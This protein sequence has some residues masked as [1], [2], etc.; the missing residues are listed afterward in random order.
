MTL[1]EIIAVH[2]LAK[3]FGRIKAVDGIGFRVE[4]GELFAFLG[5]N[6]AGKSTTINML[7]TLLSKDAGEIEI[8]GFKAGRD[9]QRIRRSIGVVFQDTAWIIC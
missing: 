4:K 5:P 9:D 1:S 3:S 7:C 6:G 8:C 2:S